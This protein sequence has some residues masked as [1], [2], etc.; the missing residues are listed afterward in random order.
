MN[1]NVAYYTRITQNAFTRI[2]NLEKKVQ[3]LRDDMLIA[4]GAM[5]SFTRQVDDA[6]NQ[7]EDI[8]ETNYKK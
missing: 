7:K 5:P 4:Y 6:I 8:I 2:L 1:T 3:K